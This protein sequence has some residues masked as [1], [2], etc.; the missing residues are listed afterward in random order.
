VLLRNPTYIKNK[1]TTY[2]GNVKNVLTND[3][4]FNIEL[5]PDFDATSTSD[6]PFSTF[7]DSI[8]ATYFWIGGNMVQ[9]DQFDYWAIDVYTL[10]ASIILV[11]ILQNMLIAFMR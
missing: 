7:F 1:D 8:V 3:T 4:V 5:K 6:N 11:V 10:I 9:R 2:S